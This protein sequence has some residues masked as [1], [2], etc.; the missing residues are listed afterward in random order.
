MIQ[1]KR[2]E[3]TKGSISY[4]CWLLVNGIKVGNAVVIHDSLFNFKILAPYRHQGYASIFMTKIIED[5]GNLKRLH[6][7][8]CDLKNGLSTDELVT[9]YRKYGFRIVN[10]THTYGILMRRIACNGE[11]ED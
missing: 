8:S 10:T 1:F 9:F 4:Y 2:R 5:N 11:S 7:K 6:A 3:Y